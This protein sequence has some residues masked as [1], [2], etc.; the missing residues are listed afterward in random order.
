M[1]N[2]NRR[3]M[4]ISEIFVIVLS[5]L[6]GAFARQIKKIIEIL[7]MNSFNLFLKQ[8]ISQEITHQN[9]EFH[10]FILTNERKVKQ[11]NL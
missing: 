3:K 9:Q 2:L 11:K 5:F 10:W 7:K 4:K 8:M 1:Q 6:T